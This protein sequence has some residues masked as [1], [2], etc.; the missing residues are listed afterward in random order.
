MFNPEFIKKKNPSISGPMQF[1]PMLFK[2]HMYCVFHQH[3]L[4]SFLSSLHK[5]VV[6]DTPRNAK[7]NAYE[8][9]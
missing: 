8:Y 3:L 7:L 1:K 5:L 4:Y 6:A 9:L 2:D